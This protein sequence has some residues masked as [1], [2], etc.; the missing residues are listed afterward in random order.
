MTAKTEPVAIRMYPHGPLRLF[1]EER[2]LGGVPYKDSTREGFAGRFVCELCQQQAREVVV[3]AGAWICHSCIS[4]SR[5][6]RDSRSIGLRATRT[7][8]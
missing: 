5:Q 8:R 4:S 2:F 1:S 3:S 6:K 7:S